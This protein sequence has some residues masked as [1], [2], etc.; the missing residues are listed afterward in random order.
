MVAAG[1]S[2]A[3]AYGSSARSVYFTHESDTLRF[4]E[5]YIFA[6]LQTSNYDA[7]TMLRRQG[8]PLTEKVDGVS[9][10]VGARFKRVVDTSRKNASDGTKLSLSNMKDDLG[11]MVLYTRAEGTSEPTSIEEVD[12]YDTLLR[13]YAVDGVIYVDG[14]EDFDVYTLH[15]VKMAQHSTLL[16]GVYVVKAGSS[17]AMV[18]VK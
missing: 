13:P 16:P 14:C 3:N 7:A 15:G 18:V 1:V 12:V 17:T 5:P 9:Y 10:T 2:E 8:A 11:W 4:A 6:N